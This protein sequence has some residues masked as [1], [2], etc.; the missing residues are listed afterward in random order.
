MQI[1]MHLSPLERS[2]SL[3]GGIEPNLYKHDVGTASMRNPL[4]DVSVPR[5]MPPNK[6]ASLG[7]SQACGFTRIVELRLT[8]LLTPVKPITIESN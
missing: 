6:A 8:F 2:I 1:R 3:P 4:A 5:P 7:R